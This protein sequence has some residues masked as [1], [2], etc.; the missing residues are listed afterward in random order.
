MIIFLFSQSKQS[1]NEMNNQYANF[2][3][4]SRQFRRERE[5]RKFQTSTKHPTANYSEMK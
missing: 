1:T 3:Y 2:T 5:R 4:S